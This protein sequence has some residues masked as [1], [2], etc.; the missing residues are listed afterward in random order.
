MR[1]HISLFVM[2]LGTGLV[3][4]GCNSAKGNDNNTAKKGPLINTAELDSAIH[5]GDDFYDYANRRWIEKNPIPETE[6]RWGVFNILADESKEVVKRICEEAAQKPEGGSENTRIIGYFYGSAM[7][8]AAMDAQK[9]APLKEQFAAIQ[10]LNDPASLATYIATQ[11]KTGGMAPFAFFVEQDMKNTSRY[12]SYMVQSGLGMPERDYY[13]RKDE[14]SAAQREAYKNYVKRIFALYGMSEAD[15]QRA[16]EETYGIEEKLAQASLT[17]VEQRDPQATYHLYTGEQLRK[18]YPGFDWNTYF[19]AL[20]IQSPAELVLGMPAYIKAWHGML[21]S[22]KPEA[23]KSYYTFHVINSHTPALGSEAETASFDFY[24]KTLK[25]ITRQDARWKRV[26]EEANVLL[27]DLIGEEYV[28]RSFDEN[29]RKK[30]LDLVNNL[31][32]AL[33]ERIS[34]LSWMGDS[35]KTRAQ[36]KLNRI[37]VKIGYPD[38]WRSYKG[39]AVSKQPYLNNRMAANEFEFKRMLAKL[40]KEIDRSEWAMGPQTVNAYYNPLL[41]EIVFPAA[42]LQPPF[43]NPEADDALNYGGIG[44][45]IGHELTHGFDDQGRQFDA[46]GNL[47]DW[48]TATDADN[49]KKLAQ[50]FVDQYNKYVPI[51]DIHINGELTLGENIADLGGMIIAYQAFQNTLRA[52]KSE[53]IDG[54]TPDQRF[55]LNFA[56]IWRGHYRKEAAI[57]RLYTDVHS[58][59]KYRVIGVLSNFEPFYKAFGVTEKNKMYTQDSLR[60]KMW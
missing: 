20:G 41:N 45:V 39:L 56:I 7:D 53:K 44:M 19:A 34:S 16:M 60:C 28:K 36:E 54:L 31:K 37:M 59:A 46:D 25:G 42:I 55:F 11:H 6:S 10:A 22:V 18:E 26:T 5:P 3:L 15:A 43:F 23:W 8:T 30:A 57:Q 33:K 13:F 29:A 27:R 9:L 4:S 14:K 38:T 12:I 2:T 48:W 52:K 40:G 17:L 21:K 58:P 1:T 50:G 24:Q 47:K 51:D 32:T 35:T 49:F